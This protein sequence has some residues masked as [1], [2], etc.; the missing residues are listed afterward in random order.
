MGSAAELCAKEMHFSREEQDA[1]AVESYKR[2]Q[3][4][5]KEGLFKNEIFFSQGYTLWLKR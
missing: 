4:S 1:F 5:T 3:T 2:A